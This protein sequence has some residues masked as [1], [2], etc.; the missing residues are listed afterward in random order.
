MANDP[1]NPMP[2]MLQQLGVYLDLFS[3]I[4]IPI[5][6][7]RFSGLKSEWEYF[8]I[9]MR[10]SL[11]V[12]G[13]GE[14]LSYTKDLPMDDVDL[15]ATIEDVETQKVLARCGGQKISSYEGNQSVHI[16]PD[17]FPSASAYAPTES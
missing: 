7:P 6:P 9:A 12:N 1:A 16:V 2:D 17:S 4:K 5:K 8:K 3:E 11:S 10:T 14:L 13:M 15:S